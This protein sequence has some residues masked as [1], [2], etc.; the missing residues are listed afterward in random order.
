[1]EQHKKIQEY[2]EN[3]KPVI[4]GFSWTYFTLW[5][6]VMVIVIIA[7]IVILFGTSDQKKTIYLGISNV[8]DK[9]SDSLDAMSEMFKR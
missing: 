3:P 6:L 9:T 4:E 2:R 1:M 8:L 7:A 5:N